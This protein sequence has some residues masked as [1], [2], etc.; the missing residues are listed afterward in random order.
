MCTSARATRLAA[1]PSWAPPQLAPL[2]VERGAAEALGFVQLAQ[3]GVGLGDGLT[4]VR[5]GERLA[6]NDW[7]IFVSAA[8]QRIGDRH[9][10]LAPRSRDRRS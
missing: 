1:T 3:P 2:T 4:H 5:G 8:L 10:A 9:L 6:R 7:S